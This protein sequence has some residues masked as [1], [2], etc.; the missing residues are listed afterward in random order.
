MTEFALADELFLAGH[1]EYSGKEDVNVDVLA[2]ALA[3][4][5]IGE[6]VLQRRATIVDGRV[7]VDDPRQW[8]DPVTDTVIRDLVRRGDG[9]VTRAWIEHLS[10]DVYDLVGQR[11]VTY[12]VVHR[13]ET[14]VGITRK[15]RVRYPPVDPLVSTRPMVRLTRFLQHQEHIDAQTA[16]LAGL[17]R[18]IGLEQRVMVE[19]SRQ[20]ILENIGLVVVRLPAT[21]RDLLASV[22]A[23]TSALS[24]VT[25]R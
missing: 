10:S 5:A 20:R 7:K 1:N 22:D 21:L 14:R 18:S 11:L 6:L 2:A 3:G 25:R 8:G 17:L 15:V 23:A 19:W 12:G 24:V 13:E 4:A 9:F 16:T